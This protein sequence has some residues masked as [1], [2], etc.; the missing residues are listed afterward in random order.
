MVRDWLMFLSWVFLPFSGRYSSS[1]GG[2]QKCYDRT[3]IEGRLPIYS[4][5]Y[6]SPRGGLESAPKNDKNYV[7]YHNGTICSFLAAR[8]RKK[9]T[10]THTHTRLVLVPAPA[11][12]ISLLRAGEKSNSTLWNYVFKTSA[13]MSRSLEDTKTAVALPLCSES[14]SESIAGCCVFGSTVW[15]K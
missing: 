4:S 2:T 14:T 1:S 13:A 8:T 9:K 7:T 15:L 11:A 3:P 10:H 6:S 12:V 5:M